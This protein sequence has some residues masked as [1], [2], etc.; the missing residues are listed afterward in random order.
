MMNRAF[1]LE[2]KTVFVTGASSGIGR[3]IAVGCARAG[4]K[5]ILNG[6][7]RD[8]LKETLSILDG[9]NILLLSVICRVSRISFLLLKI[10]QKFMVGL[11]VLQ[12]PKFVL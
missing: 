5:L 4:A 11:I 2:G 12:Y 9:K 1:S 10:Y 8:R 6:R 7:D 3:G